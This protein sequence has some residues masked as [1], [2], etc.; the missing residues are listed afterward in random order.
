MLTRFAVLSAAVLLTLSACSS[1][2]GDTASDP[3][4]D[5]AS[6]ESA[7]TES[8]SPADAACTYPADGQS[9]AKPVDPP[10]ETPEVSGT[11][12]ATISL[13]QGDVPIDLDAD[14]TP[15]TVNSFVSLAEQGY[16]DDTQCHR[17]TTQGIW[18]LQCGDP[19]ATGMG[20]PGYSFPD[21]LAGSETYGPGTL[22]MAN[23]GPDTNGSQFFI[24]YKDSPLPPSYTVFGSL[25]PEGLAVVKKIGAKGAQGGAPD[26]APA[27]KVT[28]TGVTIG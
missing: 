3:G 28:I 11:V 23:A 7:P 15:C 26:G 16:F 17:L 27:K 2:D 21:E 20:G 19:S 1:E 12:A 18:V 9:P 24:V 13:S 22:A 25:S 10:A 5:P 4:S 14:T 8:P 6:T